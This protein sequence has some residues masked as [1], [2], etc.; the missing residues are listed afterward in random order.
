MDQFLGVSS[1]R[2]MEA[3]ISEIDEKVK[4]LKQPIENLGTL[5]TAY[6]YFWN[7]WHDKTTT[8]RQ[9]IIKSVIKETRLFS[10]SSKKYRLEIELLSDVAVG[11]TT[12]GGGGGGTQVCTLFK[13]STVEPN[14]IRILTWPI[15]FVRNNWRNTPNTKITVAEGSFTSIS[16][17]LLFQQ[18]LQEEVD[19]LMNLV[20]THLPKQLADL[21]SVEK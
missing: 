17:H 6:H 4:Y 21:D 18:I 2:E 5:T 1:I 3:S 13:K 11:T 19:A 14:D 20:K 10:E 7:L 8:D 12:P 15:H 9:Q 16:Q